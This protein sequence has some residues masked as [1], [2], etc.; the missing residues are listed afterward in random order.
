M[1]ERTCK[2]KNLRC[3]VL[4]NNGYILIA[5]SRK[6]TGKFFGEIL[7]TIM[8]QMLREKI[9]EEINIPDYQGVCFVDT[10]EETN[11]ANFLLTVSKN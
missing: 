10:E 3:F 4:D 6:H 7:P 11:S 9:Y 1:C 2:S 8:Q 5:K